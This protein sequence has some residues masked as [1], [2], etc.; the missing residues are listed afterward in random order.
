MAVKSHP[1]RSVAS[2]GR[3]AGRRRELQPG[4]FRHAGDALCLRFTATRRTASRFPLLTAL[5]SSSLPSRGSA[6]LC[7][8]TLYHTC[9]QCQSSAHCWCQLNALLQC[10]LFT[11]VLRLLFLFYTEPRN[12]ESPTVF[13]E[14]E[15]P[16][17]HVEPFSKVQ[18]SMLLISS[19]NL[20]L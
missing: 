19:E 10:H 14:K 13:G 9:F 17:F 2:A 16:K 12:K 3:L 1:K 18:D 7:S 6:M 5:R 20:E 11:A 8:A 15:P 4:I